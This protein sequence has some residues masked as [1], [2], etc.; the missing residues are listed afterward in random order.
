MNEHVVDIDQDNAQQMLIDESQQR[1]VLVDFWA[2]WC[3]PCKSLMPILEKLAQEYGGQ[4]LLAKVNADEQQAIAGQFG[5]KSLPTVMLIKEG[6]PIDGF[7]GAQTE[8]VVRELL[9]KHLPK[10]WD[11]LL[12][13]AQAILQPEEVEGEDAAKQDSPPQTQEKANEAMPLLKDAY[14]QSSQ[15]SDI[16]LVLAKVYL[17]LKRFPEAET[18]ISNVPMADQ[19][20]L[21]EQVKAQFEL[22]QEAA[23]SPEIQA[24]EKQFAAD[25]DNHDVAYQLAIQ[26]SQD[27]LHRE[28]LELLFL[29]LKKNVNFQ[30]GAAKKTM[31][32]MLASMGK[33]DSL[34]VEFQRKLYTL[35]Y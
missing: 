27:N 29:I 21:Y 22:S 32:D 11:I 15:R 4:F 24:L 12:Q 34:A 33:G 13:K 2:D 19:D 31:M 9:D 25:P 14:E 1:L 5:V 16:G 30:E 3:G 18:V 10:P 28:A 8:T 17:S 6:Q 35:L 7:T 23:K 26:F 20:S